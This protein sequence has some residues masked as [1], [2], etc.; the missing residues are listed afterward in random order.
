MHGYDATL[1]E[2]F[3]QELTLSQWDLE[4][5]EVAVAVDGED[6]I[7]GIV[8]V[9]SGPD[10]CFLEKLFV[11]PDNAGAGVGRVLM[12]WACDAARQR[13]AHDMIIESDPGAVGFYTRYGARE[14]GT[15]LS[16]SVSG[17]S[18]PRLLLK[19]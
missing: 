6:N 4:E 11:E 5:D 12:D 13:G 1:L 19:L 7:L 10:G 3:R 8:Q 9:S 15:A 2:A 18:L 14:A 16:G 17:R